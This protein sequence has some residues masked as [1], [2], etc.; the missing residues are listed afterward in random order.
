MEEAQD[1]DIVSSA[2]NISRAFPT[3]GQGEEE[4]TAP[5]GT[6]SLGL[7][8]AFCRRADRA[9]FSGTVRGDTALGRP[10]SMCPAVCVGTAR[11]TSEWPS[12]SRWPLAV[13]P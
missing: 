6:H 3:P 13:S 7:I 11:L 10:S 8:H 9:P 4:W 2:E 1:E 5:P 12:L